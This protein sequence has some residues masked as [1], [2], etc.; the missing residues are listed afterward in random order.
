MWSHGKALNLVGRRA[1]EAVTAVRSLH[2]KP[3]PLHF[4][5]LLCISLLKFTQAFL[6]CWL[7]DSTWVDMGEF[8][9]FSF[10]MKKQKVKM[11]SRWPK[12]M[13]QVII[14]WHSV[15]PKSSESSPLLSSSPA[16]KEPQVIFLIDTLTGSL[17]Y[18]FVLL[19]LITRLLVFKW[20]LG[21]RLSTN[22]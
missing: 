3:A 20:L 19:D 4:E 13:H 14:N 11:V 8:S 2:R 10:H 9:I 17:I 12:M 22:L 16:S 18:L 7:V 15:S 1:L 5:S 21:H 6:G